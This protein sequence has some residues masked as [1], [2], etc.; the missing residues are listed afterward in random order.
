MADV[1]Y[2]QW[3]SKPAMGGE[4]VHG[5]KTGRKLGFPTANL[6]QSPDSIE[7]GVY[8]V[9]VQIEDELLNGVMNIGVKPTFGSRFERITEIHL[10]DFQGDL[11]GKK[12]QCVPLFRIRDEQKFSSFHS[13]L[14]QI[15]EDVNYARTV[16]SRHGAVQRQR[17]S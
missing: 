15:K 2:V 13:L 12:I 7:N 11:Y 1:Q 4:V 14:Q 5:M 17:I 8:G 9:Q 16:F 10:F 6:S 3:I